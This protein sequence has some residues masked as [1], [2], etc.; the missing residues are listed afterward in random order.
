MERVR[1]PH[2]P[3]YQYGYL[4]RELVGEPIRWVDVIALTPQISRWISVAAGRGET[5]DALVH[6][7]HGLPLEQQAEVGLP[8]V[9][10]LVLPDPDAIAGRSF[11]LPEWLEAVRQHTRPTA[12]LGIWHR[13]VDA[14]TVAGDHHI[15][16]LAD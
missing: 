2:A 9:E 1:G 8:W 16:A 15:A 5:V 12:L 10:A 11:L 14:L 6:T 4:H 13:L 7:L 3:S